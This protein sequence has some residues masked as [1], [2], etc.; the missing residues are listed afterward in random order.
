MAPTELA[1]CGEV[2]NL[3]PPAAAQVRTFS[4]HRLTLNLELL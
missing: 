2:I 3:L 4:G 1:D